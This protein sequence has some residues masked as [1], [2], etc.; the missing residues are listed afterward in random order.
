MEMLARMACRHQLQSLIL[1]TKKPFFPISS[2]VLPPT[3]WGPTAFMF[4]SRTFLS[5]HNRP[6]LKTA[7]IFLNTNITTFQQSISRAH[8]PL[9]IRA[10]DS[11]R[12]IMWGAWGGARQ[13]ILE[14]REREQKSFHTFIITGV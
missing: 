6:I 9:T 12:P 13:F 11:D 3:K 10:N 2:K 1:N 5:D 14:W 8:T 4:C 7:I